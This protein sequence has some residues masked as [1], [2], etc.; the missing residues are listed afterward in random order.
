MRLRVS[1]DLTLYGNEAVYQIYD[2]DDLC[3][4]RSWAPH[5]NVTLPNWKLLRDPLRFSTEGEPDCPP[6]L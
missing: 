3:Y 4:L 2:E 5:Y 6:Y 1:S